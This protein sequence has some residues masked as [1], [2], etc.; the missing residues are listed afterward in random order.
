[1]EELFREL[2]N[3]LIVQLVCVMTVVDTIFGVLKAWKQHIF[4]SSFGING[5]IRKIG[6]VVGVFSLFIIDFLININFLPFIPAEFLQGIHL[7]EIGLTEIFGILFIVY[8]ATSALKN[9]LSIGLPIPKAFES[10]LET[11][12]EKNTEELHKEEQ[13]DEGN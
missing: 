10:R 3:N 13:K 9:M 8:E 7:K 1:M 6:I 12:L 5:A 2:Q 4:N 11:W